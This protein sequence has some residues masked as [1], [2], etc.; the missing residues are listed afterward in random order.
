[1]SVLCAA[2]LAAFPGTDSLAGGPEIVREYTAIENRPPNDIFGFAGLF[3]VLRADVEHPD[4]AGAMIGPPAHASATSNNND[5]PF[6]EP[7]P[8]PF[9]IQTPTEFFFINLLPITEADLELVEGR[10]TYRVEDNH[11]QADTRLS[12]NLNRTEVIP[13]PTNLAVSDTTTSPVFSFTDPDPT[14]NV[15]G[16]TRLYH[17][18][19]IDAQ[20]IGIGLFPELGSETPNIQIPT[21]VMCPCL[22][23]HLRAQSFDVDNADE[24]T[25]NL[26]TAFLS[27]TPTDVPP[28]GDMSRD[29][30][31]DGRDVQPFVAALLAQSTQPMELCPGD[32]NADGTIE[33]GDI[34]GFVNSLLSP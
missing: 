16:V 10:Y 7:T 12:H 34:P 17:V 4:G 24:A 20:L 1:M 19:V 31:A 14:P 32:F 33:P 15:G 25:E 26:A 21:G 3:V 18:F 9:L 29:C 5:Y 30:A 2:A 22:D 11:G 13:L 27:F 6:P 8:L 28:N 23:Y